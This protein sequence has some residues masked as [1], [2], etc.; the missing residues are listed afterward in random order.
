MMPSSN[1]SAGRIHV[2][3]NI[4]TLAAMSVFSA[5]DIGPGPNEN[6]EAYGEDARRM[7]KLRCYH[8]PAK[9]LRRFSFPGATSVPGGS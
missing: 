9:R 6:D 8:S 7:K 3:R 4:T 1:T 2:A 5:D